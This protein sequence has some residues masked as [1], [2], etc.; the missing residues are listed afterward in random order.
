MMYRQDASDPTLHPSREELPVDLLQRVDS[1]YAQLGARLLV[2]HGLTALQAT[3]LTALYQHGPELA[4]P[5]LA[6]ITD[7][8]VG[9]VTSIMDRLLVRGL[10]SR[11]GHPVHGQWAV[12]TLTPHG[13]HLAETLESDRRALLER[14]AAGLSGDQLAVIAT[15]ADRLDDELDRDLPFP[16]SLPEEIPVS[17]PPV[18]R[19]IRGDRE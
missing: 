18:L 1:R 8:P 10:V 17:S 3:L 2:P 19:L 16:A 15:L 6:S 4:I 9:A 14:I 13:M 5:E 7:V 12:A 11:K